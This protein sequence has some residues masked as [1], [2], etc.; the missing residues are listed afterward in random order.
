MDNSAFVCGY[1]GLT[2]LFICEL[3]KHHFCFL[4]PAPEPTIQLETFKKKDVIEILSHKKAYNACKCKLN[5]PPI[6]LSVSS[7]ILEHYTHNFGLF[8]EGF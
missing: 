4:V 2:L 8:M 5:Y 1:L 3:Q 7:V 6:N